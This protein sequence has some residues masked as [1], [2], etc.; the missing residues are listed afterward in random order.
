MSG[1]SNVKITYL[2]SKYLSPDQDTS[3]SYSHLQIKYVSL[4]KLLTHLCVSGVFPEYKT[5]SSVSAVS[6]S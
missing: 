1:F 2:E 4:R 6:V 5:R 3:T